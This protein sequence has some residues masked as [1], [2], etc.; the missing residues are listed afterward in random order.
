M[1]KEQACLGERVARSSSKNAKDKCN[2]A[3]LLASRGRAGME[4]EASGRASRC[5]SEKDSGYSDTGSDSLDDQRSS[6]SGNWRGGGGGAGSGGG[7]SS[8][9]STPSSCA[10]ELTPIYI[11]K[12]LVLKQPLAVQSSSE[13]LLPGQLTWGGGAGHSSQGPAQLLFI[14]QPGVASPSPLHVLKPP[15]RKGGER[16]G[17]KNSKGT[18]LPILNS[19]P[20]IAPHPSKKTPEQGKGSGKVSM[21]E[22]QS[23]SKRVCMEERRE[24]VSTTSQTHKQQ[25]HHHKQQDGRP[26]SHPRASASNFPHP[27]RHPSPSLPRP[28]HTRKPPAACPSDSCG[29]GSPSV[30]SSEAPEAPPTPA[31]R[32]PAEALAAVPGSSARQRRF[33][34]T[35]EILSQSG[36][37]DIT[38]RTQELLRQSAAT[39]RD[40]AQLRHHAHLLCQASQ[41]GL[42]APAAWDKLLQAMAESGRYPNLGCL[43]LEVGAGAGPQLAGEEAAAAAAA[44]ARGNATANGKSS[45]VV[46]VTTVNRDN[47]ATPPSPLLAPTPDPPLD[48]LEEVLLVP[49][50]HAHA[51][52]S[53][54]VHR[55]KSPP[56]IVMPPDSSTSGC[57]L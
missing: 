21:S 4:E 5:S 36:L 7:A 20:R 38:L 10:G 25:H 3:A 8:G 46:A 53:A 43:A 19:Y 39:E 40:I 48:Y 14:Q 32:S 28:R 31:P 45:P 47:E 27:Q 50:S 33:L 16:G 12:N 35:V 34:N 57:L 22:G 37:L 26:H 9:G 1:P 44:A 56:D 23:L 52:P 41:A 2:S 42:H 13:Q 30:S 17:N 51:P 6:S 24:A 55:A 18:Y 54:R 29:L 49:P 11:I 15:S